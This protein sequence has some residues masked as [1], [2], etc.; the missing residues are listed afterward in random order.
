MS[1]D[2]LLSPVRASDRE[3]LI[4]ELFV[5]LTRAKDGAAEI[6][7]LLALGCV[8]LLGVAAAGVM[9]QAPRGGLEVMAASAR[10]R[11]VEEFQAWT[12]EGPSVDSFRTGLPV[13]VRELGAETR[14][15][16]FAA[17]AAGAG[18]RSSTALPMRWRDETVGVLHLMNDGADELG[19]DSHYLARSFADV[20]AIAV[21]RERSVEQNV[22]LTDQL[23]RALNSRVVIEQA[24][25]V[26]AERNDIDVAVAFELMRKYSRGHNRR[27]ADIA[28]AVVGGQLHVA[29]DAT[30]LKH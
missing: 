8:N 16:R 9:L 27:I 22:L 4:S 14:W 10:A 2:I 17:E 29:T 15:P 21:L 25:G 18:F 28:A 23:Q 20:I 13:T 1:V 6:L 30:S 3:L 26:L 24:K 12:G 11:P 7:E 5:V 19:A